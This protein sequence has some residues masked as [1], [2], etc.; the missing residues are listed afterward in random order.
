[1]APQDHFVGSHYE[2]KGKAGP[3]GFLNP[4]IGYHAI[5]RPPGPKPKD[6][7][8]STSRSTDDGASGAGPPANAKPGPPAA[9]CSQDHEHGDDCT[10]EGH[11]NHLDAPPL[12]ANGHALAQHPTAASSSAWLGHAPTPAPSR[13]PRSHDSSDP[14]P[15][16]SHR[17]IPASS[18]SS[19]GSRGHGGDGENA[20]SNGRRVSGIPEEQ[21]RRGSVAGMA[22]R[23]GGAGARGQQQD[24]EEGGDG[25]EGQQ[26][27]ADVYHVWRSRDNRKGRHA[28]AV[29]PPS[30]AAMQGDQD[31]EGQPRF[32]APEATSGWKGVK[33]GLKRML[34]RWPVWDV[35]FDVAVVF[36]LGEYCGFFGGGYAVSAGAVRLLGCV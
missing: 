1:M 27:A 22:S 5:E 24:G 33:E 28:L 14:H 10:A 35:S 6:I 36:T 26:L 19:G 7:S 17:S 16:P 31:A 8:P 12:A 13:D 29:V 20:R 15:Y 18:L 21:S 23:G 9:P 11:S 4:T 34:F 3:F 25:E 2:A 30:E 32:L